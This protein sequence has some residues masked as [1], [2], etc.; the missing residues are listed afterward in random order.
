[1]TSW[2]ETWKQIFMLK[3]LEA[4]VEAL[5]LDDLEALKTPMLLVCTAVATVEAPLATRQRAS[6]NSA[7]LRLLRTILCFGIV[8]KSEI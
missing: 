5:Q 8:L 7:K 3:T 6:L 4:P 2:W 1:M